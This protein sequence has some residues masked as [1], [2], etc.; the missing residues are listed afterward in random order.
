MLIAVYFMRQW[1]GFFKQRTNPFKSIL[2][3]LLS[4][5]QI[6]KAYDVKQVAQS[7]NPN[8]E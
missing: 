7:I 6:G 5:E 8:T 4:A 1:V 3:Q 2:Q